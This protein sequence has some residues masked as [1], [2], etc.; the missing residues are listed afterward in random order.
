MTPEQLK[1]WRQ[2]LT[3]TAGRPRVTIEEAARRIGVGR[4]TYIEWEQGRTAI[5]APIR[6]ACAAIEHGLDRKL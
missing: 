3:S 2:R 5:P 4:S 6:L 1:S